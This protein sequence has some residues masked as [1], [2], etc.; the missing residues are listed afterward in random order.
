MATAPGPY[1]FVSASWT[2]PS[3]SASS[4]PAYSSVWVGVGGWNSDSNRL[5]QV[6]TDQDALN[7][8]SAVYYAWRE[9]Y[10][11]LAEPIAYVSPGDSITA[12]VSQASANA[13]TWYMLIVRNSATLLNMTIRARVNLASEDTADFIV[14]RPAISV[15]RR[16]QLTALAD[17]RNV[18]FSD[19][20]TNQG[21]LASLSSVAMVVM[22]VG[23]ASS[24]SEY[25]AQ[26][27]TLDQSTNGFTVE[28]SGT[29]Q[30]VGEF[31]S[32]LI[33]IIVILASSLSVSKSISKHKLGITAVT[34]RSHATTT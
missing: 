12:T 16:D 2:V 3:V 6:G 17:F 13:S 30:P 4:P 22:R 26:P 34:H 27:T 20:N 14:E 32:Y 1:T 23:N 10:P 21:T 11:N 8:G 29:S 9:V 28:Y 33:V 19:C 25:L 18:T 5:I 24:V 7:N 31:P 15:G